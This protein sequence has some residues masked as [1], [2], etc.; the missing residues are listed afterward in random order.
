MST[1]IDLGFSN[2]LPYL[3]SSADLDSLSLNRFA[4]VERLNLLTDPPYVKVWRYNIIKEQPSYLT[5]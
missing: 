2:Q 3:A 1:F 4:A 5:L